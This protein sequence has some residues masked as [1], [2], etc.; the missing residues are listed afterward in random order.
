MGRRSTPGPQR[1]LSADMNELYQQDLAFIHATGFG[2]FARSAASGILRRL[3]AASIPVRRVVEVGCGAGPLTKTLVDAGFEVIGIDVSPE[4]LR[5]ARITC[6]EARFL[7]GSIYTQEIPSCDAIVAI[8]EP[9]TYHDDEDGDARLRDSERSWK[10]GEDWAVLVETTEDQGS[11]MLIREI[12]T[13]RK[14]GDAYRR[15]REVHRV[16]LFDTHEVCSW[17]EAAGFRAS[18]ADAYG[19]FRLYPRRRAFF[20][21]R[22]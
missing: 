19:E 10:T 15:R 14:V 2:D 7:L 16:R 22:R 1:K 20:G 9:L 11:R 4:L 8:G 12:E 17:L 5:V 18:T 6:S 21:T 13:F 3:R